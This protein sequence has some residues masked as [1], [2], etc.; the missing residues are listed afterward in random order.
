[1][2]AFGLLAPGL[3][4]GLDAGSLLP[5]VVLC[6][7]GGESSALVAEGSSPL[8]VLFWEP[9]RKRSQEALEDLA[10]MA[11]I[12]DGS[13]CRAVGIAYLPHGSTEEWAAA[14]SSWPVEWPLLF[15]PGATAYR[16]FETFVLPTTFVGNATGHLVA[17]EGG[18]PDR[19]ALAVRTAVDM[20]AGRITPEQRRS[21]LHPKQVEI[22]LLH[23][24]A[25][26]HQK[27]AGELS[28]KRLFAQAAAE[29][30]SASA[31]LPGNIGI[32][33]S[34]AEAK[35]ALGQGEEALSLYED[36]LDEDPESIPYQA[37]EAMA[38][39]LL[40]EEEE[41]VD[42]LESL[43]F[44]PACPG[45]AFYEMGRIYERREEYDQ[46]AR[47]YRRAFERTAPR[48]WQPLRTLDD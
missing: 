10:G 9:G 17:R 45:R 47:S 28:A 14:A 12:L 18:H 44:H 37:G 1:M 40:G 27:L 35:L 34:L 25:R 7:A 4:V 48:S 6:D 24:R 38:L 29:L 5:S 32:R 21:L 3:C 43:A 30:E 16:A 39:I 31:I 23:D 42:I 33:A 41:A 11:E 15:D 36:L 19:Y 26:R 20:A 8:V 13:Y 2:F 46:A 22:D